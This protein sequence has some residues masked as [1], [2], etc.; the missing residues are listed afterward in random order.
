MTAQLDAGDST[1]KVV[2]SAIWL[3]TAACGGATTANTDSITVTGAAGTTE[4]LT[5][6]QSG[7][8]FAPGA[9]AETGTGALSEIEF[10]VNLGDAT[11]GV[12]IVGTTG[13]DTIAAGTTGVALNADADFDLGFAVQPAVLEL[14]GGDGQNTLTGRGGFGAGT[15]YAGRLVLRAGDLGDIVRGGLGNDDVHG[16]AGADTLEGREGDD[17]MLGGRRQRQPRRQHRQRRHDRRRGRRHAR[18][19]RRRRHPSRRRRRGGHDDQRRPRHRRHRVL[20]PRHRSQP[21]A[22][23]RPRSRTSGRGGTDGAPTSPLLLALGEAEGG[24]GLPGR[25]AAR[26]R[27]DPRGS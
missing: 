6:D 7:G 21:D 12:A 10:A 4:N 15:V 9:T 17:L 19:Q 13:N 5:I 16:G 20:R 18:G 2:G 24:S 1:L 14:K 23:P 26:R 11:D 25:R 8:A 22:R 3:N 27:R